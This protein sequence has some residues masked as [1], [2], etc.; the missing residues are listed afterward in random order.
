MQRGFHFVRGVTFAWAVPTSP[1]REGAREGQVHAG[2]LPL[3]RKVG[4]E[5]GRHEVPGLPSE[6][7]AAS[8]GGT[9]RGRVKGRPLVGEEDCFEVRYLPPRAT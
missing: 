5:P 4:C 8:A 1:N 9:G 3:H 2:E 7:A 6:D